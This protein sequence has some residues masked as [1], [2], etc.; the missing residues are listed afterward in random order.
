MGVYAHRV[1]EI[2]REP[3]T[4]FSLFGDEKLCERLR[5]WDGLDDDGC[6]VVWID[7]DDIEAAIQDAEALELDE[8]TIEALKRDVQAA[9]DTD[10]PAV[11]YYLL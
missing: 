1:T 2:K 3:G 11:A 4:S 7:I 5:V 8:D 6:G 9:R 10:D